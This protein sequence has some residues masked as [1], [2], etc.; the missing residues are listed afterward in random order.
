MGWRSV[1]TSLLVLEPPTTIE[2]RGIIATKITEQSNST[3][4]RQRTRRLD[5]PGSAAAEVSSSPEFSKT[6]SDKIVIHAFVTAYSSQLKLQ[7]TRTCLILHV[8]RPCIMKGMLSSVDKIIMQLQ[9]LHFQ[10]SAKLQCISSGK[11]W[12]DLQ[13]KCLTVPQILQGLESTNKLIRSQGPKF[14]PKKKHSSTQT[15]L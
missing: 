10:H 5:G 12:F 2:T 6:K 3:V 11:S 13:I 15:V 14:K 4:K 1:S 9:G 8:P 7:R